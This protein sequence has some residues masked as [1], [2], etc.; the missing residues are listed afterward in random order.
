MM[1]NLDPK[2]Y[3]LTAVDTRPDHLLYDDLTWL[4]LIFKEGDPRT[5]KEL[6]AAE[7]SNRPPYRGY[8]VLSSQTFITGQ[9][10][11]ALNM[12]TRA[13]SS[14]GASVTGWAYNRLII[15]KVPGGSMALSLNI[16]MDKKDLTMPDFDQLLNSII[17]V[18]P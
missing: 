18:T 2:V 12:E 10:L 7:L 11:E 17:L 4:E 15:F 9:G 5:L 3:R 13:K 14:N 1:Q 16:V 6:R 8:K